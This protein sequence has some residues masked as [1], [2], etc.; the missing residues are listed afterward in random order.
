MDGLMGDLREKVAEMCRSFEQE[1]NRG[2][3]ELT[4]SVPK[5]DEMKILRGERHT[6][7]ED[8]A[9]G[10]EDKMI[11]RLRDALNRDPPAP[12]EVMN[13]LR[14]DAYEKEKLKLQLQ[15]MNGGSDDDQTAKDDVF[16]K[17]K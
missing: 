6:D 12:D 16:V 14:T 2:L 1:L 3:E 11:T 8:H 7:V 15:Y 4:A 9:S 13:V 17:R 10:H 5:L